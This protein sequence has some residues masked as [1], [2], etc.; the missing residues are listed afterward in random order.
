MADSMAAD[1]EHADTMQLTGE[2]ITVITP[3]K[4]RHAQLNELLRTLASQ[5]EPVGRILIAD[6]GRDAASV[7]EAY[8]ERLPVEWIDCPEPGQV[9]QRNAALRQLD[10]RTKV[11][12]YLDDDIQLEHEAIANLVA[13]WSDQPQ[14]PAGVSLNLVNMPDQPDSFFRRLFFM[15]SRPK[16]LVRRSGYNTP[17]VNLTEDLQSQWLIGGATAWRKDILLQHF[18]EEIP[19]RWAITEDLMFSYRLWYRGDVLCVCAAAR[20][21]HIDPTLSKGFAAGRFRGKAAVMWR[22]LFVSDR[23]ELSII[24]FFW[25]TLGQTLGRLAKALCGRPEEVGYAIGYGQGMFACVRAAVTG[26]DI[27]GDL[28]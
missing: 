23:P 21:Q 17:V 15:G 4:G 18:N 13:F 16:G 24:A 25:M 1:Q 14:A 3:T 12:L 5:C 20:A 19:S 10:D 8:S 28:T 22:F 2:D 6:G 7:I 11:V 9:I 27:R 26:R